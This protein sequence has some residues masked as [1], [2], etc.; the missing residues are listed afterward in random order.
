MTGINPLLLVAAAL[1]AL[2]TVPVDLGAQ[3]LEAGI[4]G[5]YARSN[6]VTTNVVICTGFEC[7]PSVIHPHF[8][9][10]AGVAGVV[11]RQQRTERLALRGEVVYARKGFGPGDERSDWRVASQYL[12]LP[13]L[14]EVVVL[15]LGSARL[16]ASGGLA[17]A[18][19]LSCRVSGTTVHGFITAG[20]AEHDPIA[21]R[22]YGPNVSYDLG[23]VVAPG[24][25]LP[26]SNGS[27]LVELRHTR[28]LLDIR[29][30]R[31]SHTANHSTAVAVA[32]TWTLRPGR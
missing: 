5:G 6:E 26:T 30:D 15:R 32:S 25:R 20:C 16:Q 27:L 18:V 28:G 14:A 12:E 1:A 10:N 2:G 13:L 11:L 19:L 24:L 22:S 3:S 31:D 8:T 23:W 21:D 29:R 4:W 9:R 17:P 7:S